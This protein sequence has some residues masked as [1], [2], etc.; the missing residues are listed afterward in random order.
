MKEGLNR[1]KRVAWNVQKVNRVSWKREKINRVSWIIFVQI[2]VLFDYLMYLV[3]LVF[4]VWR[5]IKRAP[6]N[7][8][9]FNL[10]PCLLDSRPSWN[11]FLGVGWLGVT[12]VSGSQTFI[13]LRTFLLY[14]PFF[15][16]QLIVIQ[17]C[18]HGY[19]SFI[20]IVCTKMLKFFCAI[21]CDVFRLQAYTPVSFNLKPYI[22]KLS[23]LPELCGLSL[24]YFRLLS[25]LTS[26]PPLKVQNVS[27]KDAGGKTALQ[28]NEAVFPFSKT[29]T[30]FPSLASSGPSASVTLTEIF[31]ALPRP[32]DNA[33]HV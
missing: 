4:L 32:A 2:I 1:V 20:S 24:S 29:W 28:L 18:Q 25:L 26:R 14:F 21:P 13:M 15:I 3:Y 10:V 12:I 9:I 23:V 11:D 16:I 33:P 7:R 6:W 27:T 17:N 30:A 19:Y 8:E 22:V 31:S 5:K